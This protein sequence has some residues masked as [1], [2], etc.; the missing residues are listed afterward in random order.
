MKKFLIYAVVVMISTACTKSVESNRQNKIS[1]DALY[2]LI[3]NDYDKDYDGEL[4]E[5]ERA[6]VRCITVPGF[7]HVVKIDGLGIFPSLTDIVCEG[8]STLVSVDLSDCKSLENIS[9]SD[10]DNLVDVKLPKNLTTISAKAFYGCINLSG[11]AIPDSVVEI[12]ETAFGN[13]SSLESI[14]IPDNVI[15]IGG[16]AFRDCTALASV[17]IGKNV[18]SIGLNA[19]NGCTGLNSVFANSLNT[20]CKISFVYS[21]WDDFENY[22]NPLY[23]AHNLYFNGKLAVNLVIPDTITAV[24]NSA[25]RACT[26]LASVKIPDSV[27]KIEGFAFCNCENLTS[28]DIGNGVTSIGRGAF[29]GC[30][31]I[32]ITI[33]DGVSSIGD[34]AFNGCSNLKDVY[35][36]PTVPPTVNLISTWFVERW[37]AF[38]YNASERKI[39][40]PRCSVEAY[41]NAAGWNEYADDIVG[42]DF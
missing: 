25:F 17:H 27:M 40:V 10:C 33:P 32:S 34:N 4:S 35:C 24:N 1:D 18:S 8:N 42:Y 9:F 15:S 11:I 37:M 13:C 20:W 14:I 30:Q 26:H 12:G 6:E 38:D 7:Y 36:K 5:T 2:H 39:Y 16:R 28:V 31:I 41:K 21:S 22:S 3:L 23:Y 19:F 29:S